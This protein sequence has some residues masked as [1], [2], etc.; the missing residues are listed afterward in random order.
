MGL[1]MMESWRQGGFWKLGLAI[2]LLF[3]T[4]TPMLAQ[5]AQPTTPAP[6]GTA[7][8]PSNAQPTATPPFNAQ[9]TA[10]QA[11]ATAGTGQTMLDPNLSIVKVTTEAGFRI[12]KLIGMAVRNEQKDEI[13]T[14]DDLIA[15]D[16]NH[17]IMA[18]IS[19]G[20]FLGI[21]NKLV[22]IPFDQLHIVQ[23]D[24]GRMLILPNLSKDD[25]K[26]MPTFTY[27]D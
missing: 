7:T 10:N 26:A 4:A 12:S 20:G 25:L 1:S 17:I 22:A 15:K 11:P 27:G 2:L 23:T 18:V 9:P 14:V 3:L 6:S 5:T 13:G 16:N 8:T 21:G 19:V 24:D